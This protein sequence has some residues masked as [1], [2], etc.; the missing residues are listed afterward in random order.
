MTRIELL[1]VPLDVVDVDGAVARIGE[2]IDRGAFAH[3]TTPNVD[4]LAHA[5]HD[6]A[7]LDALRAADLSVA[8]GV[9][10]L[11]MA[12]WQGT[13]LPGRVN[14]TDLFLRLLEEA[15]RRS[16]RLALVGGDPGVVEAAAAAARSRWG[17][18]VVDAWGPTRAEVEAGPPVLDRIRAANAQLVVL[19]IGGVREVRWISAHRDELGDAVVLGVGSA[20]DFL[21]ETRSRSPRWMQRTGL[22]WAW[23]LAHEPG[24]LW[25]R[26][27]VDD[28][29]VLVRFA[30]ERRRR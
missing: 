23:R 27:L 17:T 12:R 29:K 25:Q 28:P 1:D 4:F 21:A 13:P 14:G 26:Y 8:D 15:G 5:A 3:V 30:R 18:D 22:E 11:W 10:L 16:W 9:P 2:L 6:R 20:F 19:G 7:L 24:R